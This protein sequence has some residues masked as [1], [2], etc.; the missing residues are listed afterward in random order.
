VPTRPEG[1]QLGMSLRAH[2]VQYP[3]SNC[4]GSKTHLFKAGLVG[5][6]FY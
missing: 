4:P 6:D 3:I 2:K 1:Y 5:Y